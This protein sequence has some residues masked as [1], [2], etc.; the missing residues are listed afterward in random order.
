VTPFTERKCSTRASAFKRFLAAALLLGASVPAG[1]RAAG[2]PPRP[3]GPLHSAPLAAS[4]LAPSPVAPAASDAIVRAAPPHLT[5]SGIDLP[6][7]NWRQMDLGTIV[8]HYLEQHA[9]DAEK[10]RGYFSYADAAL[11]REFP[12]EDMAA[13][14]KEPLVCHAYL[15]PVSTRHAGPGH[16]SSHTSYGEHPYCEIFFVSPSVLTEVQRCCTAVGEKRDEHSDHRGVTHEYSGVLLERYIRKHGGWSLNSAPDW[17]RQGYEEY[18]A[19]TLS[20][21]HSRTVTLE[22]YKALLRE[23]PTRVGYFGVASD[24]HEGA[25]ILLFLHE[26]FGKEKLHALLRS[27]EKTF[28]RAVA[29]ELGLTPDLFATTWSQWARKALAPTGARAR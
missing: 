28:R 29:T 18:L 15:M 19:L 16:A 12:G 20:T 1:C 23:D 17:F 25:V 3:A 7:G 5:A 9:S 21:E 6:E 26:R 10:F 11:A 14:M 22:M 8:L 24:Y 27:K 4:V 13:L 2:A